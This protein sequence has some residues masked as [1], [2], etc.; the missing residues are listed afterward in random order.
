[1]SVDKLLIHAE[2]KRPDM[3]TSQSAG[4]TLIWAKYEHQNQRGT[5]PMESYTEGIL[6][7]NEYSQDVIM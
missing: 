7:L 1:M 4:D 5:I 6:A 2:S 3:N